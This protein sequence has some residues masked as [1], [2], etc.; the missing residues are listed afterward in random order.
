MESIE[1]APAVAKAVAM[2]Q[3]GK[4]VLERVEPTLS[5]LEQ[6]FAENSIVELVHRS[7]DGKFYPGPA[8]VVTK[9]V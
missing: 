9:G 3:G 1:G 7:P 2:D 5:N 6:C 4:T 8:A